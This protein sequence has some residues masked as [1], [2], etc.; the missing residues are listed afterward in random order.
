[1]IPEFSAPLIKEN[2][3]IPGRKYNLHGKIYIKREITK[4]DDLKFETYIGDD[5]RRYG[6]FEALQSANKAFREKG[7]FYIVHD[8]ELGRREIPPGTGEVRICV[9]YKFEF[10]KFGEKVEVPVYKT[11]RF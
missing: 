1:M 5:G 8:A 11:K 7:L 9:G 4:T 3:L 6:T 10:G 2:Y